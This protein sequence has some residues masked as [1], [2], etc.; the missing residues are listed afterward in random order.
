MVTGILVNRQLTGGE[1]ITGESVISSD[2]VIMCR[3][4]EPQENL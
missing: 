2:L 3:L 4:K 1:R